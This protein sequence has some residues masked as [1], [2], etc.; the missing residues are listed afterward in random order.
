MNHYHLERN[1]QGLENQLIH[2]PTVGSAKRRR[3]PSSCAF[4]WNIEFLLPQGGMM[5][6]F[7]NVDITG[8]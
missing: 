5:T 8:N 4:R 7:E 2:L 6:S 1:H 3:N